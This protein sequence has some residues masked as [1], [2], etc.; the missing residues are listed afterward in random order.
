MSRQ[1]LPQPP[2][3]TT[4]SLR[5]RSGRRPVSIVV[6]RECGRLH[7]HSFHACHP[8]SSQLA[9]VLQLGRLSTAQCHHA[10]RDQRGQGAEGAPHAREAVGG[11][12]D[13]QCARDPVVSRREAGEDEDMS[14]SRDGQGIA[15]AR[16]TRD[17]VQRRRVRC[18]VHEVS[19]PVLR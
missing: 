15:V 9:Q 8:P 16:R 6:R 4:T 1:V 2:S 10:G 3:P 5:F 17:R 11:I 14:S 7:V 13:R 12:A 19:I 18:R